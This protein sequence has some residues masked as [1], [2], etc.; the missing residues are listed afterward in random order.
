MINIILYMQ[1][2]LIIIFIIIIINNSMNTIN[3][4]E[5][6]KEKYKKPIKLQ[7]KK[8]IEPLYTKL[9][10]FPMEWKELT[11]PQLEKRYNELNEIISTIKQNNEKEKEKIKNYQNIDLKNTRLKIIANNKNNIYNIDKGIKLW[12]KIFKDKTHQEKEIK[13]IKNKINKIKENNKEIKSLEKDIEFINQKFDIKKLLYN[14]NN[15]FI[16]NVY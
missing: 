8:T 1:I 3:I 15:M 12:Y 11:D 2:I 16:Q 6:F 10:N 14:I 13:K 9:D 7:K 4:F 5:N